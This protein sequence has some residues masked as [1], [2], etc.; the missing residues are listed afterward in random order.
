MFWTWDALFH[1]ITSEVRKV[2]QSIA[3]ARDMIGTNTRS[4]QTLQDLLK[5][6]VQ[7]SNKEFGKMRSML[8]QAKEA[9]LSVTSIQMV[10]QFLSKYVLVIVVL[11]LLLSVGI[12]CLRLFPKIVYQQHWLNIQRP[13]NHLEIPPTPKATDWIQPEEPEPILLSQSSYKECK[14]SIPVKINGKGLMA[15][16]DLSQSSKIHS[17]LLP[18]EISLQLP[19]HP[20]TS[21]IFPTSSKH[22]TLAEVQLNVPT[23]QRVG[24]LGSEPLSTQDITLRVPYGE[25]DDGENKIILGRNAFKVEQVS[26]LPESIL[27]SGVKVTTY[28]L[29][30][31]EYIH[32]VNVPTLTLLDGTRVRVNI[33]FPDAIS[34]GHNPAP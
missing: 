16:I 34:Q 10:W 17:S 8:Q 25:D 28:G 33:D 1:R 5:G 11:F 20:E 2:E 30:E 13:T 21:L 6:H 26:F 31:K 27:R 32:W 22:H 3:G 15:S 18:P 4:I 23:W 29:D 12:I 19:D 24:R 9:K 7:D 14:I